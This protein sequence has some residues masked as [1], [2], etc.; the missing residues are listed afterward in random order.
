M[1]RYISDSFA[2]LE[3][4]ILAIDR[5]TNNTLV[6]RHLRFILQSLG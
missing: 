4:L 3:F 1:L 6:L 5:R 2:A